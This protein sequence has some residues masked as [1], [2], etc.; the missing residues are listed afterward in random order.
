M[1]SS[2]TASVAPR[3]GAGTLALL[4]GQA[5]GA[6]SAPQFPAFTET[7]RRRVDELLA[8]GRTVGL[9]KLDPVIA[10]AEAALAAYHGVGHCLGTSTGHAALHA[11]LIGLE[12]TG[13]DE[14]IT[15]PYTWGAS[16]AP[17]LHNCAV[18]VFADV[19]PDTGLLDPETI[20]SRITSRTRA[21]LAVHLYGQPADVTRIREIADKHGLALIEDG[22][23]AHG[24]KHRGVRIGS[25]GDVAG[26]SCMGGK[27]LATTEAGYMLSRAAEPYW[28]AT[29]T[30]QHMGG[31]RDDP[32]RADEPGFPDEYRPFLD[33]LISSYRLSTIN[34]V[35]L[36]EQLRKLDDELEG[37]RANAAR[38]RAGLAGVR[39]VALP[40]YDARDSPGYYALTLNF[41]ADHAGVSRATYLDALHAEGLQ[42]YV[43]VPAPIPAWRRL[44]PRSGAP[45]TVWDAML[46]ERTP[47]IGEADVPNCEL[48]VARSIELDWHWYRP[49]P[50]AIDRIAAIFQKVEEQLPALRQHERSRASG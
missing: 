20:E 46:A 44:Q 25:F 39:S 8:K 33:S 1:T 22:S 31:T 42:P 15:T 23:Q 45:R 27:L 11:C 28:K 16:I 2:G 17:I 36:V 38:L 49:D 13:G 48:K 47:P 18:P 26:F 6:P 4:G 50:E 32:G 29:L 3:A 5:L 40:E 34:A 43:Y 37:R 9:S 12:I 24:V 21:I 14:V 10:E 19:H 7:A 35:L 41:D 30:T